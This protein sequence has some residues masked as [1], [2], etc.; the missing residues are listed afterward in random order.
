MNTLGQK[1]LVLNYGVPTEEQ[2]EQVK[3]LKE[4]IAEVIDVLEFYKTNGERARVVATAQT[5]FETA[6]MYAV[7]AI[8][9]T[10]E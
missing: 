6:V 9:N 4:S 5:H 10:Y 3:T 8:L 7:K 2:K 1:R